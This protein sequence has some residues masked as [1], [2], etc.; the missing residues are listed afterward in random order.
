MT[1]KLN[2]LP[3]ANR[4]QR[5]RVRAELE[6]LRQVLQAAE[7]K[8]DPTSA[9]PTSTYNIRNA[10][11]KADNKAKAEADALPIRAKEEEAPASTPKATLWK[12][13]R[14]VLYRIMPNNQ[15]W[16]FREAFANSL[17]VHLWQ[18]NLSTGGPLRL[19]FDL[20]MRRPPNPPIEHDVVFIDYQ[21][22]VIARQTEL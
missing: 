13:Q 17:S 1:A 19:D 11:E 15:H 10:R 22:L 14:A 9:R 5:T 8:S 3:K 18:M 21:V 20:L 16:H 6:K 12:P 7:S 4:Q 2:Q